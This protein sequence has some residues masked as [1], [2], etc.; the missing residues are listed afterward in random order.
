MTDEQFA[1]IIQYLS[2]IDTHGYVIKFQL[3]VLF[4]LLTFILGVIL[5]AVFG[6]GIITWLSKN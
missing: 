1:A 2:W 3:L 6:R 4:D 5:G